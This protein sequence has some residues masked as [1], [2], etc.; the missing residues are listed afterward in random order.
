MVLLYTAYIYF[1]YVHECPLG[2][3][4][5]IFHTNE[6]DSEVETELNRRRICRSIINLAAINPEYD[7]GKR[8][9]AVQSFAYGA[10]MSLLEFLSTCSTQGQDFATYPFIPGSKSS[11]S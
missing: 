9:D 6:T 4:N 3:H 11:G 10:V 5:D 8:I 7:I 2:S 1:V